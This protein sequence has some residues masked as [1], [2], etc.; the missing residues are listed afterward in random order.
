MVSLLK[1]AEDNPVIA[2]TIQY[3]KALQSPPKESPRYQEWQ[4]TSPLQK[5]ELSTD[6]HSTA[7]VQKM[8]ILKLA[9]GENIKG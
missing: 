5:F 8:G 4:P 7:E 9:E 6:F 1:Q 3:K 2:M